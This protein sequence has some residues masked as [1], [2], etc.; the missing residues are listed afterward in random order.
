MDR[1]YFEARKREK[2]Q[3]LSKG[4][5][6]QRKDS[7]KGVLEDVLRFLNHTTLGDKQSFYDHEHPIL[8]G[9]DD[10]I[11]G[12][13]HIA[14]LTNEITRIYN[15]LSA[16]FV[17]RGVYLGKTT[18]MRF[19][20]RF[21]MHRHKA[22][23]NESIFM[24]TLMEFNYIPLSYKN[25]YFGDSET[26]ALAYERKLLN[27]IVEK[28]EVPLMND[29]ENGGGGKMSSQTDIGVVYCLFAIQLKNT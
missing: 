13:T 21:S 26:L 17:T 12:S 19:A 6:R 15:F 18:K 14:R 8:D 11:D 2:K 7:R 24:T 25:N 23:P 27:T 29:Q 16:H 20:E 3:P 28:N 4:G 5:R 1:L 9:V 22:K 10:S